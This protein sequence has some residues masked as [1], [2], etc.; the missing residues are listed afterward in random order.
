MGVGGGARKK[1]LYDIECVR[2]V[3][4]HLKFLIYRSLAAVFR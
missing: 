2:V 3:Y 4:R 1:H